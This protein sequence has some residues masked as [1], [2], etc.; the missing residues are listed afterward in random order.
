MNYTAE[1]EILIQ[2]KWETL[3]ES[4]KRICKKEDDWNFI[5]RAYFLAKE[6]H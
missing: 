1:D 5:K 6:A 3:L 4:C 2:S